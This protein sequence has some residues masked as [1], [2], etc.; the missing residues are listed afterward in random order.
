MAADH[1]LNPVRRARCAVGL[2]SRSYELPSGAG[3]PVLGSPSGVTLVF[4]SA[5]MPPTNEQIAPKTLIEKVC[6]HASD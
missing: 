1:I 6:E 3:L 2:P 5:D 4:P